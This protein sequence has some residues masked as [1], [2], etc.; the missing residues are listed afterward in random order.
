VAQLDPEAI[1]NLTKLCRIDCTEDELK[2]LEGHLKKVLGYTYL[3]Q[4]VNTE[5][6][7]PCNSIIDLGRVDFREDKAQN[8]LKRE[9]FLANAPDH[10]GGMIR[11]PPVLKPNP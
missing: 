11:I 2:E 9:D 7:S 5:D 4:E 8:T 10:V 6:L 1:K 3:L